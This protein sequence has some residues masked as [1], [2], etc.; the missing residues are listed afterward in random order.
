M[1]SETEK[2]AKSV[3]TTD[4]LLE[5]LIIL[6]EIDHR[7]F[8]ADA[9]C[10]GLPLVDNRLTPEL[11]LRA[12]KRIDLNSQLVQRS[13]ADIPAQ[14]LPSVLLLKDFIYCYFSSFT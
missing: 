5:C 9:L 3:K 13:I 2:L 6:T 14:V 8:S 7:P 1:D 12:A 11:F 4:D 10:A